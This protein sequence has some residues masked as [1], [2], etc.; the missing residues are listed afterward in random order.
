M[1]MWGVFKQFDSDLL[2]VIPCNRDGE[3]EGDHICDPGDCWCKPTRDDE[4]ATLIIHHDK[5]RGGY[6][7]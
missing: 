4:C 3:A 6:N 2:H 5:E 7:A 1:S